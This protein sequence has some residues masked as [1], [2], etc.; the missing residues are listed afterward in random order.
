MYPLK[1]DAAIEKVSHSLYILLSG[2]F[3]LLK[4]K[5]KNNNN[6]EQWPRSTL[7]KL[8]KLLYLYKAEVLSEL[9]YA[10]YF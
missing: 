6:I 7:K 8:S 3:K 10:S 1:R 9:C 4:D 5:K 2:D